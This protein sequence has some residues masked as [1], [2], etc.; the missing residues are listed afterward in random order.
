M[1]V[2]FPNG[3]KVVYDKA[4]WLHYKKDHWMLSSDDKGNSWVASIPRG[5]VCIVGDEPNRIEYPKQIQEVKLTAPVAAG[6][7]LSHDG[8]KFLDVDNAEKEAETK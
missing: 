1:T 3:V 5:V 7:Q 2:V 4:N 8:F 6:T